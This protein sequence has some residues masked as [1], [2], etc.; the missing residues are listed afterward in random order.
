MTS[1]PER[2]FPGKT[3]ISTVLDAL[4]TKNAMTGEVARI[5]L[6]RAAM[7]GMIIGVFYVAN[8]L[9]VSAFAGEDPHADG[10]TLG[11]FVGGF[12]FGWALVFIYYTKSELLTSTM[13]VV[14]IGAYYRR[15]TLRRGLKVLSLCYLGNLIGGAVIAGLIAASTLASGAAAIHLDASV[16]TKL[17]YVT[18]GSAG[19]TDLFVRAI[20]CNFMIN[21]AMLLIYNGFLTSDVAKMGAMIM[22]VLVFAFLGFEH[23]V[24][25]SVLFM[26]AGFQGTLDVMPALGNIGIC[27]LGNFVGGGVLIGLYYA[28]A[29]DEARYLRRRPAA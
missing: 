28:W 24:A 26:I 17:A 15:I 19:M 4:D 14:S 3:F 11:K 25:N 29:N 5:Y 12:V 21:L 23:S 1:D 13:M 6:Q 2:L 27:L 16:A 18:S 10:A 8:Y 22:S 20:L 9:T 7:A